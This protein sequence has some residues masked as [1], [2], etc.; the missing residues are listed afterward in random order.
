MS[1]DESVRAKQ[2]RPL[3]GYWNLLLSS[4]AQRSEPTLETAVTRNP[5]VK[6][7]H[8]TLEL[9][10]SH[11]IGDNYNASR[12]D[13]Y[14]DCPDEVDPSQYFS[15]PSR[16]QQLESWDCGIA[17]LLILLR[18]V[19]DDNIYETLPEFTSVM[20]DVEAQKYRSLRNAINTESIWTADLVFQLDSLFHESSVRYLFCSKTFQVQ[21]DY[22]DVGYYQ[23]AFRTDEQRVTSIFDKLKSNLCDCMHCVPNGIPLHVVLNTVSHSNCIAIVLIDNAI[24]RRKQPLASSCRHETFYVGHYVI[25]CGVSRHP[26]HL[27]SARELE[28]C[29]DGT[30]IENEGE[31]TFCIVLCDPGQHSPSFSFVLPHRFERSWRA[32]GTDEDIIFFS[33]PTHLSSVAGTSGD[34]AGYNT[35]S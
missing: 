3:N 11:L 22:K 14:L 23:A 15:K 33:K 35:E 32:R 19:R 31:S 20:S 1:I 12:F 4:F 16:V 7:V 10:I 25:L 18:W 26:D 28:A 2:H 29:V 5:K 13:Q 17:C 9:L 27:I 21:K 8:V 34:G 6:H 24:L 30:T